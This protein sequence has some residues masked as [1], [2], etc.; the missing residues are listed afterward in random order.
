MHFYNTVAIEK[1]YLKKYNYCNKKLVINKCY[2]INQKKS[3]KLVIPICI[4]I[5]NIRWRILERKARPYYNL[6][7]RTSLR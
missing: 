1:A 5:G 2:K 4:R 7:T 6:L 3:N